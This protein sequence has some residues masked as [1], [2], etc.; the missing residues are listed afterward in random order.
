LESTK[1]RRWKEEPPQLVWIHPKHKERREPS[2]GR[3]KLTS[4]NGEISC[5]SLSL[6]L[7]LGCGACR[8]KK[9]KKAKG[10]P[11]WNPFSL[12]ARWNADDL[13]PA[14]SVTQLESFIFLF[15][16]WARLAYTIRTAFHV[17]V[18]AVPTALPWL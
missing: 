17:C 5:F 8:K 10:I 15:S 1:Y 13:S 9:K 12:L 6:S 18:C 2:W 4:F 3:N 16:S 7:S 14:H 11:R